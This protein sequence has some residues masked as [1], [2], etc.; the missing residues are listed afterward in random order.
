V[1]KW[2]GMRNVKELK[3]WLDGKYLRIKATDKDLPPIQFKN[4]LI[5]KTKDKKLKYAFDNSFAGGANGSVKPDLKAEAAL[6]K[7]PFTI[8]YIKDLIDSGR[9]AIVVF[10]DHRA[11]IEAIAHVFN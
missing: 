1:P 3:T 2:D 11:P 6:K 9:N 4:I 5:S 7:V 8:K 10:S